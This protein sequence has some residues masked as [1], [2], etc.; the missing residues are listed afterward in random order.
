MEIIAYI[1]DV[2]NHKSLWPNEVNDDIVLGQH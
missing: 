2:L 1:V